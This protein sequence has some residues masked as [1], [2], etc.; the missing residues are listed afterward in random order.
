MTLENFIIL[1]EQRQKE[2][3]VDAH[4]LDERIDNSTKIEFFGIDDF[5]VEVKT[6]FLE[7]YRKIT[8]YYQSN[9][10]PPTY[11]NKVTNYVMNRKG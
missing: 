5:F 9:N 3:L 10:I 4:K 11:S 8:N 6:C 7:R 1:P 2:I